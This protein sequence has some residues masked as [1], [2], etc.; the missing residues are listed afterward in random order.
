MRF[1]AYAWAL[2]TSLIGMAFGLAFML[3]GGQARVVQGAL[4][5]HGGVLG[6]LL[7]RS[8]PAIRFSA[9]TLGHVIIGI[10]DQELDHVRRHE[11]V[12]VRQC[13]RWG[14]LFLPAYLLSSAW[15]MLCGRRAYR[16]NAF[17]K[18]AYDQER[19]AP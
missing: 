3:V 4:E 12:H 6:R 19:D 8:P 5:V 10:S 2:P 9:I 7:A 11:H 13:E 15:Q 1:L 14:P 17:E 18:Q 16:D